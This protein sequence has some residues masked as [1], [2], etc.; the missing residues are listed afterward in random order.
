MIPLNKECVFDPVKVPEGYIYAGHLKD[1][2]RVK[3]IF[4]NFKANK[5]RSRRSKIP[6]DTT[7]YGT[8]I[9]VEFID[10]SDITEERAR[11]ILPEE[12]YWWPDFTHLT[13]GMPSPWESILS[14]IQSAGTQYG[15]LYKLKT[16]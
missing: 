11:E 10:L 5:Q 8:I 6:N 13:P 7:D 12:N 14:L 3:V 16:N 9:S 2:I 15:L 4:H 1:G